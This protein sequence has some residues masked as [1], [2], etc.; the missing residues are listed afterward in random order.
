MPVE[1]IEQ[2]RRMERPCPVC[3]TPGAKPV[4]LAVDVSLPGRPPLHLLDCADCGSAFYDDLTPP[5]YE[6]SAS[7]ATSFKFYV[8][9]GAGIDSMIAQLAQLDPARVKRYLEI[10][11]GFGFALDFARFTYGWSVKGLDPSALAA[12]GRELLGVDIEPAY[13]TAQTDLGSGF[14]LVFCSELV[15]HLPAPG[16][17][18][19]LLART[20]SPRGTLLLTTPNLRA[21]ARDTPSGALY[22]TL[23]PGSHLILYSAES[24]RRTLL[25][26]GFTHVRVQE[27]AYTLHAAAALGPLELRAHPAPSRMAYRRYLAARAAGQPPDSPLAHGLNYRLFKELVNVALFKKAEL[28]FE[29]LRDSYR[30][31]YGIDLEQPDALKPEELTGLPLAEFSR[32]CPF[33]LC[34]VLFFKGMCEFIDRQDHRR[35]IEFFRA[36]IRAGDAIRAAL[37]SAGSEDGETESLMWQAR[38]HIIL[39]LSVVDGAAAVAEFRQTEAAS[40]RTGDPDHGLRLPAALLETTREELFVRLVNVGA[41]AA[42]ASLLPDVDA[43]GPSGQPRPASR[44]VAL[45]RLALT[46]GAANRF[47]PLAAQIQ[48]WSGALGRLKPATHDYRA[49]IKSF[50]LRS[51]ALLTDPRSLAD[52]ALFLVRR[53]FTI[54]FAHLSHVL[55]LARTRRDFVEERREGRQDLRAA[56]NV[57]VFSHFDPRGAVDDYILHYLRQLAEAGFTVVFV[58]NAPQLSRETFERLLPLCGLV[59]RRTNVGYDFGAYKDGMLQIP[60]LRR[61]ESLVLA[62]DS[63]YGPFHPLKDIVA[64]M[65]D[66]ADVWGITDSWE[67]H[68]HLQS[69]FL[70]FG[71]SALRSA[72]FA[73]FWRRFRYVNSKHWVITRGE[74]ELSRQLRAGGLRLRALFPYR[75][76]AAAFQS[77]VPFGSRLSGQGFDPVLRR[78]LRRLSAAVNRDVPLNITHFFWDYLIRRLGCP[79]LKRELLRDNPVRVPHIRW[80]KDV[81]ASVSAYDTSLIPNHLESSLRKRRMRDPVLP[82]RPYKSWFR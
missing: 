14:D 42:A 44:R 51:L 29:R 52:L 19:R 34:C 10:G 9:Q 20:L 3:G 26:G 24:L 39:A 36:A 48:R 45:A 7:P 22:P 74:I 63:V 2:P 65:D 23:A 79:F 25:A 13:L 60:D 49:D 77:A 68:H 71:R 56:A 64:R 62:N 18:V 58:S 43:A 41:A 72:S 70:L 59:V 4:R 32:R 57:A 47:L 55:S 31:V 12:A 66:G 50:A 69:Y 1:W 33:N 75:T 54:G 80:W 6:K 17:L 35:A 73:Q 11:C 27:H 37:R 81:I 15:E 8:E 16:E 28:V 76:V 78:Y 82:G 40:A 21:V 30:L 53:P 61:L 5:V 38:A 67:R 46:S